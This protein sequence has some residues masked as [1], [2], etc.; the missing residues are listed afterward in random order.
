MADKNQSAIDIA[1]G[2]NKSPSAIDVAM[3]TDTP[4]DNNVGYL[5]LQDQWIEKKRKDR[6]RMEAISP[7]KSDTLEE[8]VSKGL[9]VPADMV[10][11]SGADFATRWNFSFSDT[12]DDIRQKFKQ[13]H[14]NG[15][16]YRLV[17]NPESTYKDTGQTFKWREQ[18]SVLV[19]RE[20]A[21]DDDGNVLPITEDS[22]V[23]T[24]EGATGGYRDIADLGGPSLP[25]AGAIATGA[26]APAGVLWGALSTGFGYMAGE[27][28]KH[29]VNIFAFGSKMSQEE[30]I[31]DAAKEGRDMAILMA[32]TGGT[33][34]A[35]KGV[36]QKGAKVVLSDASAEIKAIR[37]RAMTWV[38]SQRGRAPTL[39]AEQIA[40]ENAVLERLATQA[41]ST[42]AEARH[43]A[44]AQQTAPATIL[45]GDL[46]STAENVG[47]KLLRQVRRVYN[48]TRNKIRT[49]VFGHRRTT[50]EQ[51]GAALTEGSR[52][53]QLQEGPR[54][55]LGQQYSKLDDIAE[56]AQPM[57]VLSVPTVEG[58][59]SVR[60][61]IGEIRNFVNAEV[62]AAESS[63]LNV[64][65]P[66]ANLS[67][68]L[69]DIDQISSTQ[70][71]Y[72]VIKTLRTRVG[73]VIEKWPWD[74]SIN[75]SHAR[76]L[77][78]ALSDVML[79]PTGLPSPALKAFT[80]QA[81]KANG[82]SR[83][84]YDM[85]D[86]PTIRKIMQSTSPGMLA[87]DIGT[88]LHLTPNVR[89]MI[90]EMPGNYSKKFKEATLIHDVL[91]NPGG[92]TKSIDNWV[93]K[94]PEGW[95][96]LVGGDKVLERSLRSAAE[97]MDALRN[98]N[99]YKAMDAATKN[100]EMA[101]T[102]LRSP[103][104]GPKETKALVDSIGEQGRMRLREGMY[105][106]IVD[107]VVSEGKKGIPIVDNKAL[108]EI[109]KE[110]KAT[111]AWQHV[112]TQ[113]DRV[114]LLGMK[115]YIDLVYKGAA[116]AG[117]SLE[118]AKAI[119]ELKRPSTFISGAHKLTVNA[120]AARVI[121]SPHFTEWVATHNLGKPIVLETARSKVK[122]FGLLTEALLE[123]TE[124][125]QN[126]DPFSEGAVNPTLDAISNI[127]KDSV[128]SVVDWAS[129][130]DIPQG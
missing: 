31:V 3:E 34:K 20:N 54:G 90:N 120:L 36:T 47:E 15:E 94:H 37:Q 48:Q 64:A 52:A 19:Y 18:E 61:T 29:E 92:A 2:E 109:I 66:L 98:S 111:G 107:S 14:P 123:G 30:A 27:L 46:V 69:A 50:L 9:G 43:K 56:E 21:Y 45:E 115:S 57:F 71:N 80:E 83:A 11:T 40:P 42:S 112:L 91:L 74:A 78:S 128:Q 114:H 100:R 41:R 96:F 26:L 6:E 117:V 82:M 97:S 108:R 124:P 130:L 103:G 39:S 13:Q 38:E 87:A 51:G 55:K 60:E 101:T 127:N 116:D 99:L 93:Q 122:F 77:Y 33:Y 76:R 65:E 44:V 85:V 1:M 104:T 53:W 73:D 119:T 22:K 8:S 75:S 129:S 67:R 118:A 24:I 17:Y 121:M 106:D 58:R 110:Y 102:L 35:L 16:I 88:P 49:A 23:K 126:F 84:Y 4:T 25:F 81:V 125:G 5:T 10:D 70:F 95:S 59:L 86:D 12:D 68:I 32:V 105:H 62:R 113:A 89:K 72:Q 28:A 63:G 79:N 7:I